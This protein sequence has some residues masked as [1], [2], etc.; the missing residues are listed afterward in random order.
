MSESAETTMSI[1]HIGGPTA[2]I[3]VGALRLL[4]DPT[5]DPAD[6][7]YRSGPVEL[8]KLSDPALAPSELEPIDA[9]LLSHDQHSDNLDLAGRAFLPRAK[10]LLTTPEGAGRLG[11]NA[12][13][14]T[15]WEAVE[16]AGDGGEW[17]RV[18]A[19][20]ARHGPPGIEPVS[21]AVAGW[22]VEWAGQRRGALYISGDTVMYEGVEE[23]IRR[24]HIGVALLHCGAARVAVR[25]TDALTFT[26]VE[27]A[28]FA[29]Q[30]EDS[31][32][33]PIHYEGWGHFSEG[34]VEIEQAFGQ[35]RLEQRLLW[36]PLGQSATVAI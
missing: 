19:T 11:G 21:G 9:V 20:P 7:W 22:I 27:A 34:R 4:T 14:V 15:P 30:A 1:T 13:G 8:H 3:E 25:G 26:G 23:V 36:L 12:R 16:L 35:A 17:V 5:F 28:Q 6:S 18:T 31:T 32:I 33:I 29:R 24:F 2:L 10:Q